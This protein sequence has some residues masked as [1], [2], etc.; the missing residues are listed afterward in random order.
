MTRFADK[1]RVRD[2]IPI[3]GIVV[4]ISPSLSLY[5]IVV[6]PAASKPTIK[7]L[8]SFFPQSLSKSF[9]NVR[10]MIV[11]WMGYGVER[12]FG[13]LVCKIDAIQKKTGY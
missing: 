6:F 1:A 7:I 9:E 12:E 3:V 4:T 5:R 11:R 2:I 10:P 8:I 13:S